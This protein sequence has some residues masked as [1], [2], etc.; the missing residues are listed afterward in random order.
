MKMRKTNTGG[1]TVLVWSEED[2]LWVNTEITKELVNQTIQQ[3]DKTIRAKPENQLE[4]YATP[5]TY[6]F[7][8]LTGEVLMAMW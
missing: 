2:I 3:H 5:H 4:E 6:G 8:L 7:I 1:L